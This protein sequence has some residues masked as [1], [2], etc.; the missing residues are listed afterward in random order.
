MIA[1][2]CLQAE[3]NFLHNLFQTPVTIWKWS[4]FLPVWFEITSSNI[5]KWAAVKYIVWLLIQKIQKLEGK[6]LVN[7]KINDY[8]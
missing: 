4:R 8:I 6:M 1:S 2:M 3:A 5:E 7:V